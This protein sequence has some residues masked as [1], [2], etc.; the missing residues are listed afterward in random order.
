MPSSHSMPL[1][2]PIRMIRPPRVDEQWVTQNLVSHVGL[3]KRYPRLVQKAQICSRGSQY[4]KDVLQ[5]LY[6]SHGKAFSLLDWQR[7]H[8]RVETE[9]LSDIEPWVGLVARP[10]SRPQLQLNDTKPVEQR[11]PKH[12]EI[13]KGRHQTDYGEEFIT[14]YVTIP[15][16]ILV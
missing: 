12:R 6:F 13:R 16:I 15:A 7:G 4:I 5:Y 1:N 9:L 11:I 3:C 14:L 2:M 10:S 8:G